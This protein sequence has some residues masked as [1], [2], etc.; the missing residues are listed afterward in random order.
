MIMYN[1]DWSYQLNV[2][3]IISFFAHWDFP[4]VILSPRR[5]G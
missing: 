3:Q 1:K 5:P 4:E 2:A